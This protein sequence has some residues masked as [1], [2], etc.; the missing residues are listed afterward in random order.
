MVLDSF[1]IDQKSLTDKVVAANHENLYFSEKI[2][3]KLNSHLVKVLFHVFVYLLKVDDQDSYV[4]D[5]F[6]VQFRVGELVF[7][8]PEKLNFQICENFHLVHDLI[9]AGVQRDSKVQ[10]G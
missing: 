9:M 10:L 6:I 2:V 8:L 4:V 1:D 7:E 5:H 3:H